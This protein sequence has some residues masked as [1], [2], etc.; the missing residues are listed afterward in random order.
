MPKQDKFLPIEY[1]PTK[2]PIPQKPCKSD[3]QEFSIRPPRPTGCEPI[4]RARRS[5]PHDFSFSDDG[6]T[7]FSVAKSA[8]KSAFCIGDDNGQTQK[9]KQ[10]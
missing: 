10:I 9:Y 3:Q 1:S 6:F 2:T 7:P 4:S 5:T 8:R